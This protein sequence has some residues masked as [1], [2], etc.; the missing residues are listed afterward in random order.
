MKQPLINPL[1]ESL[2]RGIY[3]T[4]GKS[5]KAVVKHIFRG[6]L[7]KDEVAFARESSESLTAALDG[8]DVAEVARY[9]S[10]GSP[11]RASDML[12]DYE[13][14][15]SIILEQEGSTESPEQALLA[16]ACVCVAYKK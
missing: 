10:R 1:A 14:R 9:I 3:P 11:E 2:Q 7:T 8:F 13:E 5:G 6:R 4:R 16:L 15:I 12:C